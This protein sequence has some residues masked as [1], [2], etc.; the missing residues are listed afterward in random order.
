MGQAADEVFLMTY[1]WGYTY[2]VPMAVAPIP[3]VRRVLDYAV[4]RISPQKIIMGIPNYGYDWPLPY[5]KG[6]T[7][8]K[9]I[10]HS[11][12]MLLASE[13]GASIQYD[14]SAQTPFFTYQVDGILHEVWFE[15]VRSMEQK[16]KLVKEY[17]F[18]AGGYWNLMRYFRGNWL[19]LDSAYRIKDT[20]A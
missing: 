7:K 6:V 2:S 8:A 14:E 17:D 11:E 18:L 20:Q 3:S 10:G 13:Y 1:E 5:E 19:W 4:S 12:A 16:W 15:D 9:T